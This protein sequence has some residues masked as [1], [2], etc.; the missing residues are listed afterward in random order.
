[1]VSVMMNE[2]KLY[3]QLEPIEEKNLYDLHQQNEV[4]RDDQQDIYKVQHSMIKQDQMQASLELQVR[5]NVL[6]DEQHQV[7]LEDFDE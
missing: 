4:L 5:K 1:M 2:S 7:E 3:Q 6:L